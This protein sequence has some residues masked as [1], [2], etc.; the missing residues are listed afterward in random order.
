MKRR[1]FMALL[2]GAAA[3]PLT[4][5]AQQGE[6]MRRI[7]VLVPAAADDPV[8]QTWVGA[9]L[10]GL[11][12]LGWTIGRNVQIH[13]RWATANAA[14]IRR[15]A[16]ELAA[17]APDV[18]LAHG[19]S[20]VAPLL[21]ATRTVSIVFPAVVDPVGAGFVDS[22]ARPGGNATGF[23]VFEY[24]LSGKRLELLKQ[25]AS[26]VTRVAVLRDPTQGSGTSEFAAIQ[27]VAPALRVE[28]NPVNLRGAG[29]IEHAVAAFARAPDGGLIVTAGPAARLH[30]DLIV[31]L[32]ARH[33]LP[34]VYNERSFAAA[35]GLMSYG[36]D[37]IDQYRRA[38]GY[39]DRILKGEKP[40]DLPVQA[41]TKY[42]LVINLKT[43]KALGLTV[44]D[45]LLARA[46][47]VIE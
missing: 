3:W 31:T 6:R 17:L 2:A 47:E 23:M 29:E 40:A 4:V 38:A 41:P 10:Q 13:T 5:R 26:G 32:A 22:L 14:D 12:L 25:I 1:E 27:A 9:F 45:T 42:E 15:N 24:G 8:F 30:R 11:A 39:V 16:A 35:G 36:S 18:I 20:T 28:V 7:G 37:F 34:A 21:Q 46:D 19:T 43:A 44:P 33:K